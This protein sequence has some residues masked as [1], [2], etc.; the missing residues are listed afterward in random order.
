MFGNYYSGAVHGLKFQ[1]DSNNPAPRI[2]IQL[3]DQWGTPVKVDKDGRV[4]PNG[5]FDHVLTNDQGEWWF[6]DVKPGFYTVNEIPTASIIV[7]AQPIPVVVGHA[8]AIFAADIPP[9]DQMFY[10]GLQTPVSNHALTLRN[11]IQGS[12]HGLVCNQA[13]QPLAGV[14]VNLVGPQNGQTTTGADGSFHFT[15]LTPGAYVV[16]VNGILR[17]VVVG[18]GEEE[19]ATAGLSGGLNPGGLRPGQFETVNPQLKIIIN[20]PTVDTV[21]PRVTSVKASSTQWTVDFLEEVDPGIGNGQGFPIPGGPN[22]LLTLPWV[23]INTIIFKFS[24]NVV[25]SAADVSLH[26]VNIANYGGTFS[27][28]S[29]TFTGEL[30]LPNTINADKLVLHINDTVKDAAGNALDGEWTNGSSLYPSGNSTAGTDFN[31]RINVLPGDSNRNGTLTG[32]TDGVLGT[33]VIKVRNAQFLTTADPTY[34]PFDDVNGSGNVSGVDVVAVRNRQF[35]GLPTGNPV[36]PA[37][38]GA[39]LDEDDVDSVFG[40]GASFGKGDDDDLLMALAAGSSSS[41]DSAFESSLAADGDEDQ[42]VGS[43]DDLFAALGT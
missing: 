43:I 15:G 23:N 6:L 14:T 22:Q 3:V 38:S 36:A 17:I 32:T 20:Q 9:A 21:G 12:I 10:D 13:N 41:A 33:D 31:F 26:G 42:A 30:L 7:M 5:A 24:E 19:V 37:G 11:L 34:S 4:D 2:P 35:T 16:N 40:D 29:N 27:Y 1:Q 25:I 8:E 39:S 28:D 18:S